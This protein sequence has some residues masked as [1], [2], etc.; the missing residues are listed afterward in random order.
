MPN[1][2]HLQL[3][4]LSS[5]LSFC[6]ALLYITPSTT[7]ADE[8]L[9]D[10]S[11]PIA[12]GF[13][14]AP[15]VT[16]RP[17]TTT[18]GSAYLANTKITKDLIIRSASSFPE[19]QWELR[20]MG[21]SDPTTMSIADF[22]AAVRSSDYPNRYLYNAATPAGSS[23]LS[24]AIRSHYEQGEW[25]VW[26]AKTLT[27]MVVTGVV[28]TDTIMVATLDG[29]E[30]EWF[31]MDEKYASSLGNVYQG[32]LFLRGDHP[33]TDVGL[34]FASITE[35][36]AQYDALQRSILENIG[37][38]TFGFPIVYTSDER[39]LAVPASIRRSYDVYWIDLAVTYR[40]VDPSAIAEMA[41]NVAVPEHSMA[42]KLIPLRFGVEV[43]RS[44]NAGV[45]EM[46]IE[47][48]GAKVS[49]GE[50]FSQTVAYRYLKPTIEAYGEGERNFSWKITGEAVS[51]GSHRFAAILAVPKGSAAID[52]AF[53]GH[54]RLRKSFIGEWFDGELIA[55]TDSWVLPVSF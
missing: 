11:Q 23:D 34:V 2:N 12:T 55:G 17:V 52:F 29:D 35:D 41:F 33:P 14:A 15:L 21:V 24:P 10:N 9:I 37:E 45:P 7:N 36:V 40:N 13:V 26:D 44:E 50:Y 31:K 39:K 28:D 53:S 6:G 25:N 38:I 1:R 46:G 49:V 54:V 32:L 8:I 51:A 3:T 22:V 47:Y 27:N 16:V 42:L 19:V 20:E 43:S 5:I 18:A 4:R 48:G 30:V